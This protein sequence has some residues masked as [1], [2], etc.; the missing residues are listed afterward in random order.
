METL[1]HKAAKRTVQRDLHNLKNFGL[2][3]LKGG[4]KGAAWEI[5]AP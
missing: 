3:V 4:T 1:T 2:I 5:I